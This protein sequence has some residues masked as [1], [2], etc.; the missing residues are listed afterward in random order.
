MEFI[1]N[2]KRN[3]I[4]TFCRPRALSARSSADMRLAL[5]FQW[6]FGAPKFSQMLSIGDP[7]SFRLPIASIEIG[8]LRTIPWEYGDLDT[9]SSKIPRFLPQQR[10]ATRPSFMSA[11]FLFRSLLPRKHLSLLRRAEGTGECGPLF[12]SICYPMLRFFACH[13]LELWSKPITSV[14]SWLFG[15]TLQNKTIIVIS[16][17][18]SLLSSQEGSD[19]R[20]SVA[21]MEG[22]R[23]YFHSWGT[24]ALWL[25]K[26]NWSTRRVIFLS[27]LREKKEDTAHSATQIPLP[28]QHR[29]IVQGSTRTFLNCS[30]T[31]LSTRQNVQHFPAI[32]IFWWF[33]ITTTLLSSPYRYQWALRPW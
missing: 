22:R 3:R 28:C 7:W 13:L 2:T 4:I 12:A 10:H 19:Q 9:L 27:L 31:S 5:S 6:P 15:S 25:S 33:P 32:Y 24:Q 8:S 14:K 23:N 11:F 1:S 18:Y 17:H 30:P 21:L 29:S 20:R 16:V 26:K